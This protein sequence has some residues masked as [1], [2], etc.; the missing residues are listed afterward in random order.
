MIPIAAIKFV[1][2]FSVPVI[3]FK[4]FIIV[5]VLKVKICFIK[6]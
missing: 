4:V 5:K 3:F 1:N 6:G 2:S